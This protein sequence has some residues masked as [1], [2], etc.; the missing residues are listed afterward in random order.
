MLDNFYDDKIKGL[1]ELLAAERTAQA[2][3]S[4]EKKALLSEHRKAEKS[5][6]K[7]LLE[8][9]QSAL[10]VKSDQVDLLLAKI[11]SQF[12]VKLSNIYK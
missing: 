4:Q 7:S 10:Q 9:S 5:Q 8:K 2:S 6:R 11:A 12:S 3:L 1:R